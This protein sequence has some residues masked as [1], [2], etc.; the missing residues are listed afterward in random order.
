MKGMEKISEAI[1]D[2]V[3]MEAQQIVKEAEEKAL[4]GIEKAEKEIEAKFEDGKRKTI[5][6]AEIEAARIQAQAAIK[7]RQALASIKADII[8]QIISR[9]KTTLAAIPGDDSSLSLLIKEG[10]AGLAVDKARIYVSSKNVNSLQ[11]FL[12]KDKE[13]AASIV[14]IKEADCTGGVITESIDGKF[15]IDN[16][17]E[18]RLEMLLP[19]I[20]PEISKE[21]FGLQ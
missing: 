4:Q 12:K 3:K 13:L 7:A 20:L 16:T 18:T 9:A 8:D 14:E 21:L 1:L 19:I 2:K 11:Q 6:G 5:E 15:R 17:Y 10:I